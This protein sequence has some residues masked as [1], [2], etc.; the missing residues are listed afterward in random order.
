LPENEYRK[1]RDRY[2]ALSDRRALPAAEPVAGDFS[3]HDLRVEKALLGTLI[4]G[5]GDNLPEALEVGLEPHDFYREA[6]GA[7]FS[8]IAA[9]YNQN[10]KVDLLTLADM[11]KK[12]GTFEAAGAEVYLL[13]VED[14]AVSFNSTREYAKMVVD[15]ASMRRLRE[16]GLEILDSCRETPQSVDQLLGDAESAVYDI[17]DRRHS[18]SLLFLPDTLQSVYDRICAIAGQGG[19][20]TGVPTGFTY[21]DSLTGGLQKSDLIILGGRPG[22]GKTAIT[23][24]I[25][26]NAAIPSLRQ[27]FKDMPPVTVMIF[28]LEMG[29]EQITM[30]ILCQLGHF[31]L[32]HMRSGGLTAEELAKLSEVMGVLSAAPIYIDD[33]SGQKLRPIDLRAKAR[34]IQRMVKRLGLPPMGL[35][36]IDYMQLLAPNKEHPNREREVAE[37]SGALKSLAKELDVAVLCCSQ[38]KRADVEKPD[39][40]DLRDSG[41][42]E[43]DADIVAFILR[44]ELLHPDKPEFKNQG[45]LQIKKHR[46]GPTGVV[47]LYYFKEY[48][49][50]VP[51]TY[52]DILTGESPPPPS[53]AG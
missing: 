23:L 20:L 52:Q 6:H 43:Q 31:N 36:V 18:S 25:A 24:N 11:L 7:I 39:L 51:G 49:S 28:S 2:P 12:N 21:L 10:V 14:F 9:L 41:S 33:S 32:L 44:K 13:E 46:N 38:L 30:R 42:I 40:T 26:L 47:K 37:I 19:G 5:T 50:F 22:M 45:E 1:S 27:G 34:R 8:G 29:R 48:T 53:D 4:R 17:R 35:I 3:D 16:V 15:R